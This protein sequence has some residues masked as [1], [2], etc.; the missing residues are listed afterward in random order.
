[1]RSVLVLSLPV[2]AA[3]ASPAGLQA[4]AGQAV[5]Q[6]IP[7]NGATKG[8]TRWPQRPSDPRCAHQLTG[9]SSV[10]GT[11]PDLPF[12]Q[13]ASLSETHEQ[14]NAPFYCVHIPWPSV[15]A[16]PHA[17]IMLLIEMFILKCRLCQLTAAA[18]CEGA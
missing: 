13:H 10:S 6:R 7:G 2:V 4:G 1:M 14:P 18:V 3:R 17:P 15:D 12:V 5:A 16:Y 9:D 8:V 11:W